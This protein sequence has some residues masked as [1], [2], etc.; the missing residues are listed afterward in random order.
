MKTKGKKCLNELKNGGIYCRSIR[1]LCTYTVWFGVGVTDNY[2]K[3]TQFA[4]AAAEE[5]VRISNI[6][7]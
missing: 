5:V 7:N 3:N 6:R 4:I 2:V 1:V